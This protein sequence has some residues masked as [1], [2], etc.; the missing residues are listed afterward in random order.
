LNNVA[1]N[2]NN[3]SHPGTHPASML[4][5]SL[6]AIDGSALTGISGAVIQIKTGVQTYTNRTTN[7]SRTP[8]HT[9]CAVTIDKQEADSAVLVECTGSIYGSDY[10]AMFIHDDVNGTHWV[11]SNAT[12][13]HGN[14]TG[15]PYGYFAETRL[16]TNI[17]AGSHTF[18]LQIAGYSPSHA[19]TPS[20][21]V[22]S[23]YMVVTE[24]A[25]GVLT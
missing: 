3:Y 8:A 9:T 5:G 12:H 2:A 14:G 1:D 18:T 10:G 22:S 21:G 4:T 16:I 11:S 25:A 23:N 19:F 15:D 17:G 7:Y 24:I 13:T 6:P 20:A